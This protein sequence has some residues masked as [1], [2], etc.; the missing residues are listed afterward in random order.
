MLEH[1]AIDVVTVATPHSLHAE[2]VSE[3]ASAGVAVI[4][5]KP[6]ATNLE[7]ADAIMSAVRRNNVPYTGGA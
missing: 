1:A 2:Q 7:E 5:E 3:A 4:S 6:M